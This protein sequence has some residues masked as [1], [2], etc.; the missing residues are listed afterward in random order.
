MIPHIFPKSKICIVLKEAVSL[1]KNLGDMRRWVLPIWIS[2]TVMVCMSGC[3]E[4]IPLNSKL[5]LI[6]KTY[7]S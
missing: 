7:D 3:H 1:Q 5:I 6:G 4:D 2:L